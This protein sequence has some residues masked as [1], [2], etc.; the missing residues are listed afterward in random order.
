MAKNKGSFLKRQKE[1]LKQQTE[2][3]NAYL[4]I[5]ENLQ[6]NENPDSLMLKLFGV[7]SEGSRIPEIGTYSF[8]IYNATTPGPYDEHPLIA[9]TEIHD[10]GFKGINYHWG[11][12]RS[13]VWKGLGTGLYR[14][15]YTDLQYLNQI[16]F[17]KFKIKS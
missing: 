12:V 3:K 4:E 1:K 10:W 15:E 17:E 13:Y 6:G 8:F 16:P 5:I 14:V 9:C 7:V 2:R 11:E